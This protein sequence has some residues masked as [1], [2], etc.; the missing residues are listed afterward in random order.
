MT[1]S[2]ALKKAI[3]ESGMAHLAI[4]RET[5]VQRASIMH[6]LRGTGT[7]RLDKADILAEYFGIK[8]SAPKQKRT[9]KGNR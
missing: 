3:E 8:I 9:R 4:E 5:G 2:V 6:F 1:L 7:F